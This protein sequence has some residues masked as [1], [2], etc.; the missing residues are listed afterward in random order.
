[1]KGDFSKLTFNPEKNFLRVLMQQGR[2][3]L[4]SD[5]N[6]QAAILLHYMQ[7]LAADLIGPYAGPEGNAGFNISNIADSS[8]DFAIGQG[9][10]YVDGV[11]CENHHHA[12]YFDQPDYPL[13]KEKD[14]L[15]SGTY[16]VYLDVWERHITYLEDDDIREK[17]LNGVD[18]ATRSKVLW[19][20][21]VKTL[22]PKQTGL[23]AISELKEELVLSEACLR[24]WAKAPDA[25]PEACCQHPEAKYR[26]AENQLYR[27]EIHHPGSINSEVAPTFKWSRDNGAVVFPVTAIEANENSITLTLE[28]LGRDARLSL[29]VNDWVELLDDETVLKNIANPLCQVQAIDPM[30]RTVTLSRISSALIIFS[31]NNHPLLRRWDQKTGDANGIPV[32]AS[33]SAEW[34]PEAGI[35]I[36]AG[37]K[38]EFQLHDDHIL[39][40]GDYWLI[41]ARTTSKDVEWPSKNSTPVFMSPHGVEHHYAPLAI[42]TVANQSIV[43][44]SDCRCSFKPLSYACYYSYYGSFGQGIGT[45]L[46]CPDNG[47]TRA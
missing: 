30:E 26:G 47:V 7:T 46:L 22:D 32:P 19:Q 8:G 34:S 35:E 44:V 18:T 13:N 5:W 21:K 14:I 15:N 2:V 6:E 10:Y 20:V 33:S 25:K 29:A 37:I 42:I 24:A 3:Q 38:I 4:D 36:E 17:A 28:N 23:N 9:R 16:L 45:D 39:R 40:T 43:S 11:L 12:S 31:E 1:M 27:I 41:P